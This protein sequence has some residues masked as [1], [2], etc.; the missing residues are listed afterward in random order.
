MTAHR[1]Q[2]KR[3]LQHAMVFRAPTSE[4]AVAEAAT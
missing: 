4:V 3:E 1:S 2:R